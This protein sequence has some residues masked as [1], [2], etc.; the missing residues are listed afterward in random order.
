MRMD[1][2][3]SLGTVMIMNDKGLLYNNCIEPFV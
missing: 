1:L 3:Y 2:G